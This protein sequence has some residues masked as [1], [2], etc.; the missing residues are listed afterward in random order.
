MKKGMSLI[1]KSIFLVVLI[2]IFI[3]GV[4]M[5]LPG[6]RSAGGK[7]QNMSNSTGIFQDAGFIENKKKEVEK[8]C[9]SGVWS[10]KILVY[11]KNG[12]VGSEEHNYTLKSDTL[13]CEVP[14]ASSE[15]GAGCK[16]VVYRKQLVEDWACCW[17]KNCE[18]FGDWTDDEGVCNKGLFIYD[19]SGDSSF[20][21]KC[22]SSSKK[23]AAWRRYISE[24]KPD[25][26]FEDGEN[27]WVGSDFW[28]LS[29]SMGGC[30]CDAPGC[31]CHN[32][33]MKRKCCPNA[34]FHKKMCSKDAYQFGDLELKIYVNYCCP[35]GWL[36]DDS[37]GKC[38][39]QLQD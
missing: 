33:D 37:A 6:I 14:G 23:T 3:L 39:E 35:E 9:E 28:I 20:E 31:G 7:Y 21:D 22:I 17:T 15:P 8:S 10:P 2:F 38:V 25:V 1:L 30:T 13:K 26:F 16:I 18:V 24:V 36:W 32:N 12:D 11:S 5:F 4:F 19:I 29:G 27:F 34:D